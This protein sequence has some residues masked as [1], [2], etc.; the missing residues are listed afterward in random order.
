M[1]A[2]PSAETEL[3]DLFSPDPDKNLVQVGH[4]H[5]EEWSSRC[6]IIV[7]KALVR[8]SRERLCTPVREHKRLD[9][10]WK[11][12]RE[13]VPREY[14]LVV[15]CTESPPTGQSQS[16]EVIIEHHLRQI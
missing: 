12:L 14:E 15:S 6:G 5:V 8:L 3:R 9:G 11:S 4:I 10:V 16:I 2:V 7:K 13:R 1:E